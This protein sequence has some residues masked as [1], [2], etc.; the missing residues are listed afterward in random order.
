MTINSR[1]IGKK[2]HNEVLRIR[3]QQLFIHNEYYSRSGKIPVHFA[4]GH[5]AIAAAIATLIKSSDKLILTHRNLHYHLAL[6]TSPYAILEEFFLKDSGINKGHLGS[7]NLINSNNFVPYTSNI[8]GNNISVATG[9]A[10]GSKQKKLRNMVV[11]VT[12]DGAIEE[13][14][15]YENLLNCMALDLPM[16]IIVENNFWSLATNIIERRKKLNLKYLAKAVGC[17]Y[18]NLKSNNALEYAT[19]LK[20]A[21]NQSLVTKVPLVV[22]VIIETLGSY[23]VNNPLPRTINYHS[24]RLKN[25]PIQKLIFNFDKSDPVWVSRN[26]LSRLD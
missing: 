18:I 20:E 3:D 22:E 2:I 23:K 6:K 25:E 5:E 24:G 14:S 16:A 10:L 17:L 12:G 9:I 19:I 26:C 21:V 4:F 13:G 7:M 15:F 8:L 11:C 1:I